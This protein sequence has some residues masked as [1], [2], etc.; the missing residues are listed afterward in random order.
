MLTKR[1]ADPAFAR[2]LR[3]RMTNAEQRLWNELRNRKLRGFKFRRQYPLGGY[4]VDFVCVDRALVIEVDGGQHS[5]E[6][7]HKRQR[8]EWLEQH[9]WRVLRFWNNEVHGNLT[10]VLE[11][12]L[13]ALE[14]VGTSP[15]PTPLPQAG[16]GISREADS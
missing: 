11:R 14:S 5:N 2:L 15:H 6:T 8:T 10:G 12:I 9:G 4:V 16:E 1:A 3:A 13:E 7:R